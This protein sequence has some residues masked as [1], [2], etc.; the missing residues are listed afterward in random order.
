MGVL[1]VDAR[2]G[3]PLGFS[4]QSTPWPLRKEESM[5]IVELQEL[6]PSCHRPEIVETAEL[7]PTCHS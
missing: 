4:N 7:V 6:V 2:D 3:N 1:P 5:Q